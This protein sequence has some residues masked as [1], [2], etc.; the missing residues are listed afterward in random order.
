MIAALGFNG[1]EDLAIGH[2]CITGELTESY[3]AMIAAAQEQ[4]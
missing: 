2:A 1:D 4:K 3:K